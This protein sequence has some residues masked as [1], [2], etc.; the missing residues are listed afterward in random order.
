[1][2]I[3]GRKNVEYCGHFHQFLTSA[4]VEQKQNA[5]NV[6]YVNFCRVTLAYVEST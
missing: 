2:N 5:Q 6:S 1:V 4:Y 3:I